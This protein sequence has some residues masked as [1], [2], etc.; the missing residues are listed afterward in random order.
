MNQVFDNP[1][2][3][4]LIISNISY[5]DIILLNLNIDS[6]YNSQQRFFNKL[7]NFENFIYYMKEY[8]LQYKKKH[9]ILVKLHHYS[10]F[11]H[12]FKHFK[13]LLFLYQL[14]LLDFKPSFL[15]FT[16][17]LDNIQ[18]NDLEF[19]IMRGIDCY[20]RHF[21]VIKYQI[22][23]PIK[24]NNT[25]FKIDQTYLLTVFQRYSDSVNSWNKAGS[26]Q[27]PILEET[28]VRLDHNEKKMLVDRIISIIKYQ[29]C[30][31]RCYESLFSDNYQIKTLKV[32][33]IC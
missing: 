26:Y 19:P 1:D 20:Q 28:S 2:L 6:E 13:H 11:K 14:P 12:S 10:K 18:A 27:G 33:L 21:I 31:I 16:D 25:F 30:N 5:S 4:H 7:I 24:V 22:L 17:Y 3:C 9:I 8:I 32:K 15:G 29:Q 23:D